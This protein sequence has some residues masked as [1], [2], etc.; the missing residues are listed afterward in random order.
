M[1][2]EQPAKGTRRHFYYLTF[3]YGLQAI[4]G[5]ALAVPAFMYLFLPPRAKK[6]QEWVDAA[7]I[8]QIPVGTPQEVN[9]RINKVDGW[10]V[11]SEKTTAWVLKASDSKVIA[12]APQCTHLGCA[13][14][15]ED[16][17]KTFVCPCHTSAFAPDG[18]VLSG[19][20]PRPLD[21]Y[22]VRIAGNQL[23]IGPLAPHA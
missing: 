1:T 16:S 22:E 9:F 10:K 3:I 2:P 11:T 17:S 12:F 21:R 14:H 15:W 7:D 19:P 8:T 13:Y 6:K 5:A 20:A 4:M 18:R 23:Q